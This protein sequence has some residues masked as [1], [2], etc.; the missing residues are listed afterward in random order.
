MKLI[1]SAFEEGGLIPEK[2]TCD[3]T[4]MS[5]P[6]KWDSLPEGTKSLALICDD[7]DAPM[8]TWVHWVYYDIP[9]STTGV[10]EN[11]ASDERPQIGGIQG[12]AT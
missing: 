4:D 11:V 8:G 10:P 1:S 3:G 9:V 7:P 2:Y 5:P 6:L 12:W